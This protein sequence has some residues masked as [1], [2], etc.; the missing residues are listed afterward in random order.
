MNV[1]T[2]LIYNSSTTAGNTQGCNLQSIELMLPS[3]PF[4]TLHCLCGSRTLWRPA[5]QKRFWSAFNQR[6]WANAELWGWRTALWTR[7]LFLAFIYS[8]QK[9]VG[10]PGSLFISA[11]EGSC[12]PW[13][14]TVE[15]SELRCQFSEVVGNTGTT[16][17]PAQI[18]PLFSQHKMLE[19]QLM[20]GFC[21]ISELIL[22]LYAR[23]P[24]PI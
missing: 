11:V 10:R 19:C 1:E 9:A 2:P 20:E 17:P 15:S 5:T 8:I 13:A 6:R 14:W 12:F 7:E 18:C 24:V 4:Q 22:I 23:S 3:R 21:V 16:K